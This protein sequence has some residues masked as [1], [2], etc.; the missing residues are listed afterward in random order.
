M[1]TAKAKTSKPELKVAKPMKKVVKENY[2]LEEVLHS[3]ELIPTIVEVFKMYQDKFLEAQNEAS[4][5]S[6]GRVRYIV[7]GHFAK[8]AKMYNLFDTNGERGEEA[9]KVFLNQFLRILG[10][11]PRMQVYNIKIRQF[12]GHLGREILIN[13]ENKLKSKQNEQSDNRAI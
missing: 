8:V 12:I 2:T 13:T 10:K 6:T 5:K 7:N 9:I 11:D 4:K 1:T 3:T